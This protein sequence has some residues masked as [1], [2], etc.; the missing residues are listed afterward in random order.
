MTQGESLSV[1]V[2]ADVINNLKLSGVT[3]YDPHSDVTP[4]LI[5]NC[6][7]IKNHSF[8]KGIMDYLP[9][10]LV[11]ISPDAGA[12]KKVFDLASALRIETVIEC[13]KKRDVLTGNLSGFTVPLDDFDGRPCLIVD[14][15]CD[16]G[17][18]FLG[19]GSELKKHNSG[20]LFLA[21]SHG[22]FSKGFDELSS[23]FKQVFTTDSFRTIDDS[24]VKQ[25]LLAELIK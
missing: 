19:L 12:A 3:I 1:K 6:L 21:I 7:V 5:N 15:I 18:T 8:I 20:D 9:K 16:G 17:G 4:A 22:I 2:Y 24:T 10:D 11:L 23:I 25:I 13:G 14:D